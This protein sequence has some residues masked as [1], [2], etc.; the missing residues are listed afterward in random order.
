MSIFEYLIAFTDRFSSLP[1]GIKT[2][3]LYKSSGKV[4]KEKNIF[5]SQ[6]F[7]LKEL[8]EE[9]RYKVWLSS[10]KECSRKNSEKNSDTF[11][12]CQVSQ[13]VCCTKSKF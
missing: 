1:L 2:K 13:K 6:G 11:Y 4:L 5:V 3:T 12:V 10:A 8:L 7:K 9:K